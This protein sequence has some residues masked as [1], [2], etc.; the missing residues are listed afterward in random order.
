MLK[1]WGKKPFNRYYAIIMITESNFSLSLFQ[2][3]PTDLDKTVIDR[4]RGANLPS[5]SQGFTNLISYILSTSWD[6]CLL[7][8][9]TD[10]S[11]NP[12]FPNPRYSARSTD[13]RGRRGRGSHSPSFIPS[14]PCPVRVLVNQ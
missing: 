4:I 10:P 2:F 6:G 11:L 14:F 3:V 7:Y 8:S 1:I 9:V 13:L 5:S 12:R